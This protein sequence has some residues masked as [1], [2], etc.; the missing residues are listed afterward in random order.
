MVIRTPIIIST[1]HK[2][3]L[4]NIPSFPSFFLLLSLHL[5]FI[6][7]PGE[8]RASYLGIPVLLSPRQ[9]GEGSGQLYCV[10]RVGPVTT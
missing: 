7:T 1:Q 4:E 9:E 8:F 5:L 10:R 6:S 2:H 3:R